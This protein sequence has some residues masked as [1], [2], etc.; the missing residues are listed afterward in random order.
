MDTDSSPA[1]QKPRLHWYHFTPDRFVIALMAVEGL[2]LLSEWLRCSP[3]GYTVL[4]TVATVAAALLL[5]LLWFLATLVFR[6]RFR[7]GLRS[8][9]YL[10]VAVAIPCTWLMT[11]MQRAKKQRETAEVIRKSGGECNTVFG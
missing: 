10:V 8:V 9:L 2:L 1:V 5:M 3:K 7:Y 4:I 11:E 6:W